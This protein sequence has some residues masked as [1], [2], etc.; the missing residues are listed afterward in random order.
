M[1]ITWTSIYYGVLRYLGS[2]KNSIAERNFAW[3]RHNQYRIRMIVI[4]I[5]IGGVRV[6][7]PDDRGRQSEVGSPSYPKGLHK[8]RSRRTPRYASRT[9]FRR[10]QIEA[11]IQHSERLLKTIS[12][13]IGD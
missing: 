12:G 5:K 10:N 4:D 7:R 13:V 2:P 3:R 9:A 11:E 8:K 1:M 6:Q